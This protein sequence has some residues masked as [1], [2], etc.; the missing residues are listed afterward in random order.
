L[1]TTDWSA[2]CRT[3]QFCFLCSSLVCTH[4]CEG[5]RHWHH[6]E[7]REDAIQQS[8]KFIAGAPALSAESTKGCGYDLIGIMRIVLGSRKY[9]RI[10]PVLRDNLRFCDCCVRCN[11]TIKTGATWCSLGCK[12]ELTEGGPRRG[13]ALRQFGLAT[14]RQLGPPL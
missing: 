14:A 1:L 13:T 12:A 5:N 8:I 7:E 2:R 4:C 6:D 3:I 10:S 11:R 9:I